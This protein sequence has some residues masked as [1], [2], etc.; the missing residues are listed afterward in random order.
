MVEDCRF[1]LGCSVAVEPFAETDAATS[2]PLSSRSTKL[3]VVT[4][5]GAIASLKLAL[6]L[7]PRPTPV[8]PEAGVTL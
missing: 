4:L 1:A 5:A 8:A 6:T 3:D 2:L 7:V